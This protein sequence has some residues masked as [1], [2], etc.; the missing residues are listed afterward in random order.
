MHRLTIQYD[1]KI[2]SHSMLLQNSDATHNLIYAFIALTSVLAMIHRRRNYAKGFHNCSQLTTKQP[3]SPRQSTDK[4]RRLS[5]YSLQCASKRQKQ[6]VERIK[7]KRQEA[8]SAASQSAPASPP[9]YRIRTGS[10]QRTPTKRLSTILGAAH[11]A[12]IAVAH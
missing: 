1:E 6:L 3:T 5:M 9:P 7:M 8:S 2:T 12:P 11:T 10:F 4:P